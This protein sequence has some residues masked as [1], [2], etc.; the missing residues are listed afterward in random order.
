[1]L[2]EHLIIFDIERILRELT[3]FGVINIC[4]SQGM[5]IYCKIFTVKRTRT[6]KSQF[7]NQY[8]IKPMM[9]NQVT[10]FKSV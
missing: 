5:C 8:H 7:D 9:K 10:L 6:M 1:M 3:Y 4:I 2:T